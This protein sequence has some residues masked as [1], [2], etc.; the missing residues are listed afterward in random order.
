MSS[1]SYY[2]M[3]GVEDGDDYDDYNDEKEEAEA[4]VWSTGF[5]II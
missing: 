3:G 5:P 2:I 1:W 4:C